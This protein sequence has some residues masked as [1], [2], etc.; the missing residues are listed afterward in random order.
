MDPWQHNSRDGITFTVGRY[1]TS[2]IAIT[3]G[4]EINQR[5]NALVTGAVG[6]GKSNLIS[7]IV[8]SLCHRYS[9]Q[10]L[11]LYLLDFKEGVTLQ[12]FTDGPAGEDWRLTGSSAWRFSRIFLRST[13]LE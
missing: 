3:L 9:P 10:E 2:A 5:H 8:H 6:Q 1:G 7:V 4:D 12:R 13:P 11:Q